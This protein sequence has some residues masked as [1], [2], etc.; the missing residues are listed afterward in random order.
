M[1]HILLV[2]HGTIAKGF[3]DTLPMLVGTQEKA[4]YVCLEENETVEQFQERMERQ[5]LETWKDEE[6]LVLADIMSGTPARVASQI[7][8]Q[9]PEKRVLLCGLNLNMLLEAYLSRNGSL[10]E[11]AA[12]LSEEN[13]GALK[14]QNNLLDGNE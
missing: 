4:A 2:S 13:G 7:C 12:Y 5:L 3:Y 6:V 11:T 14:E 8:S 10:L 9:C 1:Y